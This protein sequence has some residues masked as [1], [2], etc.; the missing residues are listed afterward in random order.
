MEFD[1]RAAC[2][3]TRL[4]GKCGYSLLRLCDV[5]SSVLVKYDK[6]FRGLEGDEM[7][8]TK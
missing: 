5:T 4:L 7:A 2:G 3:G 1:N 6:S 8:A